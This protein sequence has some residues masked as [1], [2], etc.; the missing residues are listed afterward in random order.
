[1]SYTIFCLTYLQT[2]W[3]NRDHCVPEQDIHRPCELCVICPKDGAVNGLDI[4]L[5]LK[6]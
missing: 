2:V 3:G 1:M 5:L 6:E 4:S